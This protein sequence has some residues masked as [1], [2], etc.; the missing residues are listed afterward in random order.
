M[1]K[2]SRL[3]AAVLALLLCI[4][5]VLSVAE[6]A[7]ASP[8]DVLVL[9]N[10][11]P[12][13]RL[14]HEEYML[15]LQSY[16]SQYGYDFS[17]ED[18]MSQ[19]RVLA[20]EMAIQ[21]V[22]MDQKAIDLGVAEPTAEELALAQEAAAA[23]WA[24]VVD[25]YVEYYGGLTAESTEEDVA[26][27]RVA[28]VA[29][30]ESMGYNEQV[31]LSDALESLKYSK[32]EQT[33][34]QDA[35]VTDAE[36]R[37]VY[38]AYANEDKEAYQND[39]GYYE[40]MT[41]YYGQT[42]FYMPEGYR[43]VTHILL[44]VDAALLQNYKN[45]TAMLEE[46]DSITGDALM[47]GTE[48]AEAVTKV[49]QADVDAAEAEILASVQTTLDE[50]NK[51]LEDGVPF[52]EL[53]VEYGTDPGME[54]EPNKSQGYAVHKDSIM[55]DP[56]FTAA[57]FSVEKVGEVAKPVVG[58]YGVHIVYYLR[59]IPGGIL[60]MSAEDAELLREEALNS[61]INDQ[62]SATMAQW[63]ADAEIVYSAAALE[64]LPAAATE[65]E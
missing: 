53:I 11:T 46:A 42:S 5:P 40:Y 37:Q 8:D 32:V 38:E 21:Y 59:D 30:L 6:T 57:A 49:S 16:F 29:M 50:I 54:S 17:T 33:M 64:M 60:P 3:L 27:A 41:Q 22:L 63:I 24:E 35:T 62:M 1:K 7:A 4:M 47:E 36:V 48:I 58:S 14:Q 13:T 51:K 28:M 18:M 39:V 9:V 43:G 2:M 19:L 25:M 10:G 23:Q 26:A 15:N 44:E 55:W 56:A 20:L 12:V 34:V 52:A 65:A 45:L 61:K 31:L